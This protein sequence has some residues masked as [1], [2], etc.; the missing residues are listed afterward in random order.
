M[1]NFFRKEKYVYPTR[2]CG[3]KQKEV[4]LPFNNVESN[5]KISVSTRIDVREKELL[6]RKKCNK[7]IITINTIEDDYNGW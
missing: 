6:M 2:I 4:L 1:G 5:E 3:K 7:I